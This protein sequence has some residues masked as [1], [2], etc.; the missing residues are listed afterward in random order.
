LARVIREPEFL[1]IVTEVKIQNLKQ[2]ALIEKI[3]D[4]ARR[5][6][7][8]ACEISTQDGKT[9]QEQI[10]LRDLFR[11]MNETRAEFR[12]HNELTDQKLAALQDSIQALRSENTSNTSMMSALSK[13]NDQLSKKIARLERSKEF[14]EATIETDV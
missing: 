9:D 3:E 5:Q 12:D 10:T 7:G 13:Q 8:L 4:L 11:L 1:N 2:S 14:E 6:E